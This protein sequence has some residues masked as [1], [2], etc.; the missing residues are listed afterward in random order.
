[1]VEKRRWKG[2][3][4]NSGIKDQ[5][6]R[7]QLSMRNERT[8][9]RIFRKTVELEFEKQTAWSSTGLWE[10]SDWILWRRWQP[11]K[12]KKRRQEH[13][14]RKRRDGGMPL[15]YSE[16]IALRREQCGM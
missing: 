11:P 15:G 13:S 7:W 3:E 6:V 16:R 5:D 9:G 10:M 2:L 14:P 1:M 8:S 12:Q 4:C